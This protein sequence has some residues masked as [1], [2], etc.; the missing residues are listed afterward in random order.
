MTNKMGGV[1]AGMDALAV[2]MQDLR[3]QNH[4][5]HRENKELL[6]QIRRLLCEKANLLVQVRPPHCP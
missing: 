1:A 6:D 2:M 4:S 5:L 3:T